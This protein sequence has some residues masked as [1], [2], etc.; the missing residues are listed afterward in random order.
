MTQCPFCKTELII[1]RREIEKGVWATVEVCPNCTDEWID[2]TEHDRL[3]GLF[4]RKTFNLGGSIAVRIPKEIADLLS[5]SA[6]TLVNFTVQD[7]KLVIAK[8]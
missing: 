4:K 7:G 8:T 6:G 2:E 5:I 3:V 1:E